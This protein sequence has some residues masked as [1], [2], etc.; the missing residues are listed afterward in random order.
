MSADSPTQRE[1]WCEIADLAFEVTREAREGDREISDVLHESLDCH[2][3][4]IY[5]HRA[6]RVAL[7]SPNDG[8][9]FENLV[10]LDG[11]MFDSQRAYFAMHADVCE[12]S[13]FNA[14]PE[15][16]DDE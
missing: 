12:H 15:E 10:T 14:D 5:T 8:E 6:M 11:A 7:H 2:M 16:T 4:V 9:I 1:Y 3:W 13:N